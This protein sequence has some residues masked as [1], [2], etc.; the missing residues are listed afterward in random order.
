MPPSR[1][2]KRRRPA[3]LAPAPAT[4]AVR[5]GE[6]VARL[7]PRGSGVEQEEPAAWDLDPT[8]WAA[9]PA[10]PPDLF[11]VAASLVKRSDAY[12]AFVQSPWSGT[13]FTPAYRDEVVRLGA[14][15]R[16]ELAPPAEV[17]HMWE[18]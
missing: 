18:G 1:Q 17:Q 10:W 5:V 2:P 6:I 4:P 7:L 9:C 14:L 13:L 11:A 15:W 12:S 16:T 8:P 3:P